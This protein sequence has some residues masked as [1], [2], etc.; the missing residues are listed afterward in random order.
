MTHYAQMLK[1]FHGTFGVPVRS[2]PTLLPPDEQLLRLTLINSEL[3]ELSDAM[4]KHD[5]VG[6]AD[7]IADLLYVTFGLAVQMG[8]D[9][10]RA[11]TEVHASNITK[12]WPDGTV[13]RNA[14]GKVLKPDTY[15]PVD[16]SW[17]QA[18]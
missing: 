6:I 5:I 1:Q 15:T 11:F 9:I 17:V 12:V 8:L 18:A 3:G 16:L 13:H 2:K 7:G 10:D 14:G 4:Q